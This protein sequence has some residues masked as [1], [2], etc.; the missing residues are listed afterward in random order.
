MHALAMEPSQGFRRPQ[1]RGA[2]VVTDAS[3]VGSWSHSHEE[4]HDGRQVYVSSDVPL[5]PSRGRTTFTLLAD[6]RAVAGL[7]GP[8]D[9]GHTDGGTW[10]LSGDVLRVNIPGGTL[11]F[12]VEA[13]APERLEL[14][15]I[16]PRE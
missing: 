5:P 6:Q 8:D 9:R 13:A 16:R 3:M 15:P 4:D 2:H 10:E 12:H 14:R 1:V 7:P 11:T